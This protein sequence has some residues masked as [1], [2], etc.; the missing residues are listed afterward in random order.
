MCT[1]KR[2]KATTPKV[3]MNEDEAHDNV[4]EVG[5]VSQLAIKRSRDGQAVLWSLAG[6]FDRLVARA[7]LHRATIAGLM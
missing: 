5:V 2:I 1:P 4:V 6:N 3:A 7:E